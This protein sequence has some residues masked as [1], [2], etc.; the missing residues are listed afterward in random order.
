[1]IEF[2]F[3]IVEFVLIY[4]ALFSFVYLVYWLLKL[5]HCFGFVNIAG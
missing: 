4:N 3:V 2:G 5:Y 1:M